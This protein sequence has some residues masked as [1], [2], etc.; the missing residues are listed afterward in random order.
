MSGVVLESLAYIAAKFLPAFPDFTP[1]FAKV[2]K[3]I[4]TSSI[5][6]KLLDVAATYL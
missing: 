5:L 1:A 4:L 6:S 2:P 3:I